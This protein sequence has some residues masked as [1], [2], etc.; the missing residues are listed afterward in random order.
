M[1]SVSRR[2]VRLYVAAALTGMLS[3]SGCSHSP[4]GVVQGALTGIGGQSA[5]GAVSAW[6]VSWSNQVKGASVSYSPDGASAGLKAFR[7]GQAHF[8]ASGKPLPDTETA[9]ITGLC[10]SAGAL[11]L[12]AGVLPVGVAVKIDGINDLVL[13]APTLAA[14]LRGHVDRWNDPQIAALNA[15]QSLPDRKIEVLAEEGPSETTRAVNT[16][17]AKSLGASWSP[18]QPDRWPTDV[19][20]L[21]GSQP[22]DLANKLDD[23][24]GGMAVLDGSIIGNRFVATQLIFD[25]HARK[26]D[27]AS[28]VDAVAAGEVTAM[29]RSVVQDLD[30]SAGYG[31]ATVIYV[32]VCKQYIE[33]PLDRLARS[34]GETLLGEKAQKDANSY[35][36][37]MSPSKRAINE[38][39]ALVRTIGDAR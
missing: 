25:G 7:D 28:V 16:Y 9:T 2:S 21:T 17:L 35:S 33:E 8:T 3:L 4:N 32:N 19:K 37:V 10:T 27:A 15:E 14:I 39:L 11:S 18:P 29:P 34:F 38:G 36:F 23:T 24:E 31:L 30:Y 1:I 22:R 12:V 5:Q 26:M 20:G 6:S 13:D